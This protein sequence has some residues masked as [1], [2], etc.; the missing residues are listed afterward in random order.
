MFFGSPLA[1][2]LT[3]DYP[4]IAFFG[5]LNLAFFI[6]IPILSLALI[7]RRLVSPTKYN[8]KWK[9]SLTLFWALNIASL[10]GVGSYIANQFSVNKTINST[11]QEL[12][13]TEN[14]WTLRAAENP[15]AD[16]W[17]SLGNLDIAG[18]VIASKAVQIQIEKSKDD[19]FHIEVDKR[20]RGKNLEA[21][22]TSATKLQHQLIIED[23]EI[24]FDPY[25]ALKE[26]EKWR[27]QH[28]TIRL[29]IPEGQ[30]IQ[31]EDLP[32][33]IKRNIRSEYLDQRN[34]WYTMQNGE[35]W[36][37]SETGFER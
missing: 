10:F 24:L 17:L 2:A 14:V 6:G 34:S 33:H 3:P 7:A 20:S 11:T 28:I 21:A 37:M 25:F 26:G 8:V 18:D 12:T 22:T 35:V 23:N 19:L 27:N 30:S 16:A 15:Y 32:W 5:V 13:S 9:N 31:F 1:T 36:T 4:F 29:F